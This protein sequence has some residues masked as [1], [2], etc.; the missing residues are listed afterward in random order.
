M[1]KGSKMAEERTSGS[2]L[3]GVEQA[4]V[5]C[6]SAS[7]E[8]L[9]VKI[10]VAGAELGGSSVFEVQGREERRQSNRRR[11]SWL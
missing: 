5:M 8:A 6:L 7:S 2:D 1:G 10:D 4:W 9:R 3:A 11:R